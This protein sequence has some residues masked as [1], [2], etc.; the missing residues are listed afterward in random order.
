MLSSPAV[1]IAAV[2]GI[3]AFVEKV[4]VG[5]MKRLFCVGVGREFGHQIASYAKHLKRAK[6]RD[7]TPQDR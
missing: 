1:R 6:H 5:G 4:I 2:R 7:K 3:L